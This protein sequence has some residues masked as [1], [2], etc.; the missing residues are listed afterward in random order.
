MKL[1]IWCDSGANIHSRW[2][3][4][5]SLETLGERKT[6]SAKQMNQSRRTHPVC[7]PS[8]RRWLRNLNPGFYTF[9]SWSWIIGGTLVTHWPNDNVKIYHDEGRK[10]ET[11]PAN[12][13]RCREAIH[14]LLARR[15]ETPTPETYA[16]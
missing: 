7:S 1:K 13:E 2:E 10:T 14:T 4:T 11:H 15:Q 9:S 16:K 12:T 6:M 3:E 8:F 5:L